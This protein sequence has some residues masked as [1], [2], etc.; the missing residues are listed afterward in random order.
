MVRRLLVAGV[1]AGVLFGMF[2]HTA[3]A[4]TFGAEVTFP[5]SGEVEI[6]ATAF[7]TSI[8]DVFGSSPC[9]TSTTSYHLAANSAELGGGE[10]CS[11]LS[12]L[13]APIVGASYTFDWW[14]RDTGGAGQG[15]SGW[16]FCDVNKDRIGSWPTFDLQEDLGW[17]PYTS[18]S[19][20]PPG[21][22]FFCVENSGGGGS[23][24][25]E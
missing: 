24:V 22:A 25:D 18:T 17:D 3:M 11:I 10:V 9:S 15:W 14:S 6:Y 16:G 7:P 1:T 21:S 20:A 13:A 4:A 12:S 2:P 23:R 8:T 5:A 19:T